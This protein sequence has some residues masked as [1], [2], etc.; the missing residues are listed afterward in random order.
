MAE[1]STKAGAGMISVA[2]LTGANIRGMRA[3]TARRRESTR[4]LL[5]LP[6]ST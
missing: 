4:L 3:Y 5:Q 1:L 2:E 6:R